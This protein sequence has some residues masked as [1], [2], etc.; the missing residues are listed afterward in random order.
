[1]KT[2]APFSIKSI[3]LSIALKDIDT[4]K[5]IVMGYASAFNN[6]DHDGDIVRPGAFKRTIA[7]RGPEGANKIKFLYQHWTDKIL[8]KPSVL[9]EDEKGLYFEAPISQTT[10]GKDALVLYADGVIDEHSIGYKVIKSDPQDEENSTRELVELHLYE[11]SAVTFGA[12]EETP[13]LGMKSAEDVDRIFERMQKLSRALR[14]EL[15]DET[16][17]MLE[18]ELAQYQQAIVDLKKS[19]SAP[20]PGST[21]DPAYELSEIKRLLEE[22]TQSMHTFAKG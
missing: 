15:S 18:I 11:F 19:L 8:G 17:E 3:P 4:T 21:P 16:A 2:Q 14:K 20:L 9:K 6:R 13:Y 5:G 10:W 22:T 1:M 12:N 7:A